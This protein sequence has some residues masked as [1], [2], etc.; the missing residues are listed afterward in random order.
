MDTVLRS[1]VLR[2]VVKELNSSWTYQYRC[3]SKIDFD[4]H[5]HDVYELT[6]LN[7]GNGLRYVGSSVTPYDGLDLVLINPM[8]P[9]SYSIPEPSCK[10]QIEAF[11]C[12]IPTQLVTSLESTIEE[13][14][15]IRELFHREKNGSQF[16]KCCA[17]Y[18]ME[19]MK[20][21]GQDAPIDRTIRLLQLFRYLLH[22]RNNRVISGVTAAPSPSPHTTRRI[23]L[24]ID[25]INSTFC[26]GI[27]ASQLAKKV[28]V[29]TSHLHRI[30]KAHTSKTYIELV[31]ELKIRKAM[32]M[33]SKPD[34]PI[35]S[36][37]AQCGYNTAANFNRNFK[38][39]TSLTPTEF[40]RK[41]EIS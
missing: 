5:Y 15:V 13:F 18:V 28:N 7:G 25:T 31:N 8:V 27:S 30:I 38:L 29:S 37:R 6:V 4:W 23:S 2:A 33:L 24:I 16:P 9:H 34:I 21:M 26:E 32:Y 14:Q 10:Q 12:H 36:V 19:Q 39:F 40:R 1:P 35:S 17:K 41:H 20:S 22:Q 11:I 3:F